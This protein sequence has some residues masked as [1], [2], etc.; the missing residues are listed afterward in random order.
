MIKIKLFQSREFIELK[1]N[2][3]DGFKIVKTLKVKK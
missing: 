1:Y 2:Y 3:W